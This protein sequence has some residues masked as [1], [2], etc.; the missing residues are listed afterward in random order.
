MRSGD[1]DFGIAMAPRWTCQRNTTCAALFLYRCAISST[2]VSFM[3]SK[4]RQPPSRP[5]IRIPSGAFGFARGEKA[6]K[7]MFLEMHHFSNFS[8]ELKGWH[9]TCNTAG[10]ILHIA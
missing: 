3:T 6:V 8:C 4:S 7:A 2:F 5:H 1:L 9:S 10:L